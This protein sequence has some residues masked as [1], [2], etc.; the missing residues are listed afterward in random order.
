MPW[1]PAAE[2]HL[3]AVPSW[4]R[5]RRVAAGLLASAAAL[6]G[7]WAVHQADGRVP[8]A[9]SSAAQWAVERAP[10]GL[11]TAAV[12]TLGHTALPLVTL[13]SVLLGMAVGASAAAVGARTFLIAA[14]LGTA[15]AGVLD[16]RGPPI[17]GT[18]AAAAVA[19]MATPL[20]ALAR[21]ATH[22]ERAHRADGPSRRAVL[23]AIVAT[24]ALVALG[25]GS[26]AWAA[27]HR[28]AAGRVRADRS[29]PLPEDPGFADVPGLTP[30]VTSRDDHY[31]VAIDL[32]P[33]RVDAGAWRLHVTGSV[34]SPLALGLDD[35]QAMSTV[36]ELAMLSCIS[37]PVGGGLT[38]NARWTGVP[39]SALLATAGVRPG[40]VA[41]RAAAADGYQDTLTIADALRPEVLVAF[42]MDG[43]LLPVAHGF[44]A[45]LLAPGTYGM[46][47][48]KW[49]T[50]ITVLD[51]VEP[52]YWEARGWDTGVEARTESR[53][54]VPVD[55]AEV[56]SPVLA[57]GVAWAGRRRIAQVQVSTDDGATWTDALL[58]TELSPWA[59]R[60]WQLRFAVPPGVHS[61]T[62]R[63]RDGTGVVQDDVRRPPHPSGASGYHR[64][65]VTVR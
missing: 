60:R 25:G 62:V 2:T 24:A 57:A 33:P 52:G 20:A 65:V 21:R 29:A 42:G 12:D 55:H 64:I 1:S 47:N 19:A 13:A 63:A 30:A 39:L 5:L 10:G 34:R 3:R 11:A 27:L 14:V 22:A 49:L 44:P 45:R 59:W 35:L 26:A 6:A 43:E 9:P 32:D 50:D 4:A 46:K 8:F 38:G 17:V 41:V 23:S 36:E 48:V 7:Q 16:P 37:N 61:L 28:V 15:V 53:F 40:A 56:S 54:D 51:A 18:L 58:E 31:V